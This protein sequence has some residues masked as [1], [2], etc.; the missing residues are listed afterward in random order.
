MHRH[1]WFLGVRS[2]HAGQKFFQGVPRT[3]Q[4]QFCLHVSSTMEGLSC[5]RCDLAGSDG[6]GTRSSGR[7][8]S[9]LEHNLVWAAW[10]HHDSPSFF[11]I[12]KHGKSGGTSTLGHL[13][14]YSRRWGA[15]PGL[16]SYA[17][18]TTLQNNC[19]A[20]QP[21]ALGYAGRFRQQLPS[22]NSR[23]AGAV[24]LGSPG[25]FSF[26]GGADALCI[27]SK[28][29]PNPPDDLFSGLFDSWRQDA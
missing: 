17:G 3:R 8:Y 21:G 16:F 27:C 13:S 5:R 10:H 15:G 14:R 1:N 12:C 26:L 9:C 20:S 2:R 24:H 29:G 22:G 4:R 18:R 6:H 11:W 23:R 25:E 19:N 7:V 28:H